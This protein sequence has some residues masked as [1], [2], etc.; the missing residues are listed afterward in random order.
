MI[1]VPAAPDGPGWNWTDGLR[2][3]IK[4]SKNPTFVPPVENSLAGLLLGRPLTKHP[5]V[6]ALP[7][8]MAVA[9]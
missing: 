5:L 7:F 9:L 1:L 6:C 2:C 4:E 8:A 3:R